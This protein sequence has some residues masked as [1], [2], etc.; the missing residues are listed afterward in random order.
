MKTTILV[1]H[2]DMNRFKVIESDF[3]VKSRPISG[4]W[5]TW[6]LTPALFMHSG[7]I[8]DVAPELLAFIESQ[9]FPY[10]VLQ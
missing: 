9:K 5:F 3:Q 8:M 7:Y 10:T 1:K 2:E 6:E 4:G